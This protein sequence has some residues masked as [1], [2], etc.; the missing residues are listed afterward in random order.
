MNQ[1]TRITLKDTPISSMTKLSEGNPGAATVLV[2]LYAQAGA[3]DPQDFMGGLGSVLALDSHAIYGSR[4]WMFF[5]DV[6]GE[7][8]TKVVVCLRA[9]QLGIISEETLAHAIDNRGDGVDVDELHD[10]VC[11]QL[12]EFKKPK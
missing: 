3:I 5:K 10:K 4:I 11:A 9:V 7:D 1:N 2:Q 12:I 8:I 6:C